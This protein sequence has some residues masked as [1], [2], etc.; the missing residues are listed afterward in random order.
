M[1]PCCPPKNRCIYAEGCPLLYPDG[2]GG[3]PDTELVQ[4][5][6][7]ATEVR[8][9]KTLAHGKDAN[10]WVS[11][12]DGLSSYF[13]NLLRLAGERI[14][15]VVNSVNVRPAIPPRLRRSSH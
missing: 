3:G 6:F 9:L 5:M 1:R 8:L 10:E 13:I 2:K 14:S 12:Q 15:T 7:T 11:E 4:V